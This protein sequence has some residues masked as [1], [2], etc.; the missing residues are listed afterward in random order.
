MSR[1][2]SIDPEILRKIARIVADPCDVASMR[3]VCRDWRAI[4]DK[5]VIPRMTLPDAWKWA[6][7]YGFDE[8]ARR[9]SLCGARDL[10]ARVLPR[11][12]LEHCAELW[13]ARFAKLHRKEDVDVSRVIRAIAHDNIESITGE[14]GAS[15]IRAIVTRQ[16]DTEGTLDIFKTVGMFA[17]A[18]IVRDLMRAFSWIR[19]EDSADFMIRGVIEMQRRELLIE[20]IKIKCSAR[21]VDNDII[22]RQLLCAGECTVHL[23][24]RS[25]GITKNAKRYALRQAASSGSR[26]ACRYARGLWPYEFDF[27]GML[28]GAVYAQSDNT[29]RL[30]REWFEGIARS[31][32]KFIVIPNG[33]ANIE[34]W[35]YCTQRKINADQVIEFMMSGDMLDLLSI[36]RDCAVHYGNCATFAYIDEWFANYVALYHAGN[37]GGYGITRMMIKRAINK[38]RY[39]FID[40]MC[41]RGYFVDMYTDAS[42]TGES[43][44]LAYASETCKMCYEVMLRAMR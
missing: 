3:A 16:I 4:I 34:T 27:G 38:G 40:T 13:T 37:W 30:A 1:E 32:A 29:C 6:T 44:S 18:S 5:P 8:M 41:S 36:A 28:A 14:S 33:G 7:K 12:T 42:A 23:I 21:E 31:G 17:N 39:D 19:Y 22:G 15:F 20:L 25:H 11:V 24:L 35:G 43:R 10:H 26:D 2:I 9:V